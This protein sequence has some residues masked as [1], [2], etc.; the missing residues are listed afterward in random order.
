[1]I[2]RGSLKVF[3]ELTI[4]GSPDQLSMLGD[5]IQGHLPSQWQRS[6]E[7]ENENA[8][9][10]G[11]DSGPLFVFD[12]AAT[13]ELP[14][15]GLAMLQEGDSISVINIVPLKLHSLSIDQYNAILQEFFE[16]AVL[17][18]VTPRKLHATLTDEAFPIT[19]WLSE[20]ASEALQRFSSLANHST[21][22]SHPRDRERW[23][24]FL[25][26]A[27]R[28]RCTLD[29]DTL[30]RWLVEMGGWSADQASDLAIEY[31][32]ARDLLRF[33]RSSL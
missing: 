33:D 26:S 27:H 7:K 10:F 3:R 8:N 2:D 21:G 4:T 30:Q 19:K 20:P 32:F 24:A 15:A 12:R 14:A 6:T 28:D 23:F 16:A 18:A 22:S 31:E 25:V 1:M 11:S 9:L 5:A 13:R 17:P 29:T